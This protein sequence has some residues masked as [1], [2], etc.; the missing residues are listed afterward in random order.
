[1]DT[2]RPA[3]RDVGMESGTG[4]EESD[5]DALQKKLMKENITNDDGGNNA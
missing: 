5:T 3:G 4:A 1:M 2:A